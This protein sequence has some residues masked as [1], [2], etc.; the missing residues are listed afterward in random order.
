MIDKAPEWK[1]TKTQVFWGEIA[2]SDHVVQVYENEEVFLNSLEMYIQG[3]LKADNCNI[4]IATANH[5]ESLRY[6]LIQHGYVIDELCTDD[7]LILLNAEDILSKFMVN[8]WPDEVLFKET[9]LNVIARA[10]RKNRDVRAF[11][12]MVALLWA[13]GHNGATVQ[14]ENLWNK[15]CETEAL[16]LFCAYPKVG[17]TQNPAASIHNICCT[18]TKMVG[19]WDKSKTEIYYKDTLQIVK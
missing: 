11:G 3:G 1:N 6:R 7:R 9:I 16:C 14:L 5:L 19:G 2:P 15:F 12:E 10:R 13:Q 8:N 18:H 4:V 17:F